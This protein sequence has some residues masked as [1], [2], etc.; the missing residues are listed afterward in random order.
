MYF[1]SDAKRSTRFVLFHDLL[2]RGLVLFSGALLFCTLLF[3]YDAEYE[4]FDSVSS[5]LQLVV[6]YFSHCIF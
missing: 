4:N 1:C 6:Y 2:F 5:F 3:E